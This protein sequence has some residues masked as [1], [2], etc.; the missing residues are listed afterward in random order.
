MYDVP[1]T[2]SGPGRVYTVRNGGE[3]SE[4]TIPV[5]DDRELAS[6][7][8]RDNKRS[9]TADAVASL[10]DLGAESR[11]AA[12]TTVDLTMRFQGATHHSAATT[13]LIAEVQRAKNVT[14]APAWFVVV[15]AI[16]VTRIQYR[17]TTKS[18]RELGG[19]AN[20]SGL[21]SLSSKLKWDFSEDFQ[22][23]QEFETPHFVFYKPVPVPPGRSERAA[24]TAGPPDW[25]RNPGMLYVV[26]QR[27]Y[28]CATGRAR[29][30][31]APHRYDMA[32][33][34]ARGEL[35]ET[36]AFY[37]ARIKGSY[38]HSDVTPTLQSYHDR[39]STVSTSVAA[40]RVSGSR[41]LATWVDPSDSTEYVLVG[42]DQE[43]L[44]S[45]YTDA[46]VDLLEGDAAHALVTREYVQ[47]LR[48]VMEE[49]VGV[50]TKTSA[51][52]AKPLIP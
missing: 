50:M 11:F 38:E 49:S 31:S 7:P 35:V 51:A 3:Y 25:V 17:L 5:L 23:T 4:G 34:H 30:S 26:D 36:R 32:A 22:L 6:L 33:D 52:E 43:L 19:E 14:S 16:A 10:L 21:S 1:R 9:F 41:V 8:E 18:I 40:A 44:T 47:K 48:T 2:G 27:A 45:E 24:A 20:L 37:L 28:V 42:V 46:F 29:G 15:E 13:N 39:L 12:A